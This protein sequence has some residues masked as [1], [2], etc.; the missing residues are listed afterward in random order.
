MPSQVPILPDH[1]ERYPPTAGARPG[2]TVMVLRIFFGQA[3]RQKDR[4]HDEPDGNNQLD[5]RQTPGSPPHS[6]NR[7]GESG[8]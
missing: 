5:P 7:P 3:Q 2:E 6:L 4:P 1:P 8:D